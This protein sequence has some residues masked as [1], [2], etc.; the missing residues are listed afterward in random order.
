M[1]VHS[2]TKSVIKV[3]LLFSGH[4]VLPF[5]VDLCLGLW[6]TLTVAL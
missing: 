3:F 2:L 1:G 4:V 5:F 6:F